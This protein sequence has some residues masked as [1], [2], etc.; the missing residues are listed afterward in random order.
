MCPPNYEA[1]VAIVPSCIVVLDL[2]ASLLLRVD[3]RIE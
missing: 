2:D 3:F 1:M